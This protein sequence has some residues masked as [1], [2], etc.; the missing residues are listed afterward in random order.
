[1]RWDES[2]PSPLDDEWVDNGEAN[3]DAPVLAIFLVAATKFEIRVVLDAG[4]VLGFIDGEAGA[5]PEGLEPFI[6]VVA[7]MG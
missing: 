2:S 7:A 4:F 3:E 1:L 6:G 5:A